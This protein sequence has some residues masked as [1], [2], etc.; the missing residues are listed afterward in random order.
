ME[1][2]D[3]D[4][5]IEHGRLSP[6]A[7]D[8]TFAAAGIVSTAWPWRYERYRQP[9]S[10]A[11]APPTTLFAPFAQLGLPG[12]HRSEFCSDTRSGFT[13]IFLFVSLLSLPPF[14]PCT[15]TYI[16]I[17]ISLFGGTLAFG[18][19]RKKTV[20]RRSSRKYLNTK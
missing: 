18:K 1:S 19:K 7:G 13:R 5:I 17:Y 3:D 2:R 6:N 16:Y 4:K 12:H 15:H 14:R 11:A 9:R 10:E 20:K 8:S